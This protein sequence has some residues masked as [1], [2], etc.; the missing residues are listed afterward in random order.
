MKHFM[1]M[2]L[3]ACLVA[4]VFGTIGRENNRARMLYGL[5]IFAEFMCIGLILSWVLYFLP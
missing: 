2:G 4:L 3:F 5:K 1:F